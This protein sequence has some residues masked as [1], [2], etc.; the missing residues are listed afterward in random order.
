VLAVVFDYYF[1]LAD[2][3]STSD[4]TLDALL[5]EMMPGTSRAAF[6]RARTSYDAARQIPNPAGSRFESYEQ[7]WRSYGEGLF[8]SLGISGA[9]RRYAAARYAAHASAPLYPDAQEALADLRALGLRLGV[10]SD[11]DGYLAD[12]I[13]LHRV[14]VDAVRSSQDLQRYKP[15]PEVFLEICTV[16]RVVPEETMFVGDSPV[17]DIEGALHA[18]LLAAWLNRSGQEWPLTSCQ[19]TFE[20]SSLA[21]LRGLFTPGSTKR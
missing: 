18:G 4:S 1:T 21:E 7:R 19:P 16:L 17:N 3:S 9:G 11:A 14:H 12:S 8:A 13:A 6:D 2:P 5:D 15:H 10:L 20:V